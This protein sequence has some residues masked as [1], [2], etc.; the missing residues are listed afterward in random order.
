MGQPMYLLT[1]WRLDGQP[2]GALGNTRESVLVYDDEDLM[3]RLN[4]I[5]LEGGYDCTV[6]AQ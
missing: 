4:A 5:A 6:E 2:F 3:D 1:V